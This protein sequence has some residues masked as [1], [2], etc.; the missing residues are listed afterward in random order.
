MRVG[1][2][3]VGNIGQPMASQILTAGHAL[4][5]HDLRPEAAAA[6]LAAGATWADTPQAV[7]SQCEVVATCLPGPAEMEHV[8]LGP[9][10]IVE[11]IQPGALYIDHTTN[12]PTLVRRVHALM[13]ARGVEML[14][15][16]VSGGMEGARTRDLLVM[17]GGG[18]ATFAR[19]RPLLEALAKRVMYTGEIGCGCICKLMHNCAV[20]TL[21]QIMAE[22]WTTGVK[23]GVAPETL[24]EV[25]TQA[26]LG[27]MTNLKVRLPDT[28][29]RGDFTARFALQLARKDVGLATALGREVN[30]PMRL[31]ALCE[32]DLT[33]AMERGWAVHDASIVLTLQEER[34]QTQVRLP[35]GG[36]APRHQGSE[37]QPRD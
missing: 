2:I 16:P 20:F 8:T 26:A 5:V 12:S 7:A 25:F 24:V 10:G 11:G 13:Q 6:L 37:T 36:V 23:A 19:A 15:A 22:C 29:L 4:V 30:V 34:A 28:Y 9:H 1:F 31:A 33:H 32:Q 14:D 18:R 35:G 27:H 21:D 17:V 3:G